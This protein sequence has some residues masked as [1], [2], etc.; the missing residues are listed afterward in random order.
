LSQRAL[1]EAYLIEGKFK[2]SPNQA[3]ARIFI[4]LFLARRAFA[5][6]YR[7]RGEKY[8]DQSLRNSPF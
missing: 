3:E 4:L 7:V 5:V 1:L 8:F 2:F 6:A